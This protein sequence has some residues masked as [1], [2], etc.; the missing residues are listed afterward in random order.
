MTRL[1]FPLGAAVLAATT[2]L[3]FTP[4]FSS[5]EQGTF[6][7]TIQAGWRTDSGT[8]TLNQALTLLSNGTGTTPNSS[9]YG[10]VVYFN[11]TLA[12]NQTKTAVPFIAFVSC[13]SNPSTRA[14]FNLTS[15]RDNSTMANATVSAIN[16]TMSSNST[17]AGNATV[18]LNSTTIVNSTFAP[19]LFSL[20]ASLGASSVLLYSERNQ[21]CALNLT[22]LSDFNNTIPIFTSPSS[23]VTNLMISSQFG[24]V[25]SEH[26]V[27]NSTLIDTAAANLTAILASNGTNGLPT[28]FLIATISASYKNDSASGVVA[29]IGRAP[30]PTSSARVATGTSR[31]ASTQSSGA[32]QRSWSG[33]ASL[34]TLVAAAFITLMA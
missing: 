26:Q 31:S 5:S 4:S 34:G 14:T 8:G 1:L 19:D 27:F 7:S 18:A 20:A 29:T 6:N 13:D 16:S 33:P 22:A 30:T 10:V 15:T 9:Y 28:E 3:A 32:E 12:V 25:D 24:N 2:A 21:S 23:Q 11:E 17:L